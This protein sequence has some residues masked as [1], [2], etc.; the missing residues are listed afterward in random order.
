MARI[1]LTAGRIA[2][3]GTEAGQAFLWDTESPGL[4]VRATPSGAKAYIFQAKLQGSA[5][6]ITI[7]DVRVWSI[8]KARMEANSFQTI[9]DQGRD[10]REEKKERTASD[11]AKRAESSRLGLTVAEAWDVYV[12]ARNHKWS[13]RH[14]LDHEKLSNLGGAEKKRGMGT[15]EAGALAALMPLKLAELTPAKIEAWLKEEVGRRPTQ[16]ALAYRLLRAFLR[17][18]A[19]HD[20]YKGVIQIEAVGSRVARNHVPRSRA[21]ADDC[22]QRE[23]LT[24]WF[25]AV[26]AL[27]NPAISAYLQALLLTGA[28]REEMAALKWSDVDFQWNSLSIADKVEET[29]RIIP[30]TPYVATLLADLKR[31]NDAPPARFRILEGKPIE[32]DLE[33]WKPSPWVFSSRTAARG[34]IKEPRP[35]HTRALAAAGLPH[36]SLHGLRRSFG[37]L[38]EWVECPT[39]VVAQIMGHKPSAI[40]EKHYRRRPLDLLRMWHT[41]IE[42]WLLAQADIHVPVK[43]ATNP[44]GLS[45]L[46]TNNNSESNNEQAKVHS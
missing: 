5:I 18:S 16:A 12:H 17:W 6:R 29:G 30:L 9:I 10:P 7:G 22:L 37:T 39:G 41:R 28:R 42:D 19:G 13:E 45:A 23:Q 46:P 35:A 36:I 3:F 31:L 34:H 32:N 11:V 44:N 20:D 8:D 15:T 33:N 40:A 26:R 1:K 24:A 14:R 21:K 27:S 38:A 25:A 2:D 4:A 43:H